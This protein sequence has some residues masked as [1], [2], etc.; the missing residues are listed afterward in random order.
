MRL[1]SKQ[2]EHTSFT[3]TPPSLT[4]TRI[5]QKQHEKDLSESQVNDTIF[6]ILTPSTFLDRELFVALPSYFNE[7]PP[8]LV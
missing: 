4:H 6:T 2:N 8:G 1:D 5:I 7:L 3:Y